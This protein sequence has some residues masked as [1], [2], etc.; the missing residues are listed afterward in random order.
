MLGSKPVAGSAELRHLGCPRRWRLGSECARHAQASRRGAGGSGR[1][2]ALSRNAEHAAAPGRCAG[3]QAWSRGL[4][5]CPPQRGERKTWLQTQPA[6]RKSS[7]GREP[8]RRGLPMAQVFGWWQ[9]E[10]GSGRSRSLM[11]PGRGEHARGGS[12]SPGSG[13]TLCWEALGD[14]GRCSGTPAHPSTQLPSVGRE[15]LSMARLQECP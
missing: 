7:L 2:P 10:A 6:V 14:S 5:S 3:R 1:A 15:S 4:A 8:W 9:A 11:L 12:A 13:K